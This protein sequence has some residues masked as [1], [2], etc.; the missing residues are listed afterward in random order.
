M[1]KLAIF[2]FDGTLFLGDTLPYV[3]KTWKEQTGNSGR[4]YLL[5]ARIAP[6][7]LLYKLNFIARETLKYHVV[8]LFHD[9]FRGMTKTEIESLFQTVFQQIRSQFNQ[10][11]I[12]EIE[13]AKKEGYHTVLL[14]GC[15]TEL[16]ELIGKDLQFDTVLGMDLPFN[17]QLFDHETRPQFISG[18]DKQKLLHAHFRGVE[19]N[20]EESRSY[21]DSITDLPILNPVGQPTAVNPEPALLDIA[22]IKQ[23]RILQD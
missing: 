3:A 11:I 21:A 8:Q 9:L 17:H 18:E 20:W 14:S 15:Y 23:W 5:Y 7:V 6:F 4:Y 13:T 12:E 2:D 16:L 19:I 1:I 22:T 10:K